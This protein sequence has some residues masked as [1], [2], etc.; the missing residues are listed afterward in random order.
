[1]KK[2]SQLHHVWSGLAIAQMIIKFS[3]VGSEAHLQSPNFSN[4]MARLMETSEIRRTD[5]SLLCRNSASTICRNSQWYAI[6]DLSCIQH[7]DIRRRV[8]QRS[9]ERRIK[10][11]FSVLDNWISRGPF[12]GYCPLLQF[13]NDLRNR[14]V[15]SL[16]NNASDYTIA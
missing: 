1:M 5:Y 9:R 15:L 13:M 12:S 8:G 10:R 16:W 14:A 4:S 11:P 3:T 7:W 6:E 2:D